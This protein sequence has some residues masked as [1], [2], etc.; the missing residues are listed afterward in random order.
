MQEKP[1]ATSSSEPDAEPSL[2]PTSPPAR[3]TASVELVPPPPGLARGRYD[4][5]GWVVGVVAGGLLVVVVAFF[6]FRH[7]RAKKRSGYE[8]VAPPSGPM[9]SRR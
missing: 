1:P 6:V 3:P 5:P 8:S 4:V 7:R 2:A 9:S